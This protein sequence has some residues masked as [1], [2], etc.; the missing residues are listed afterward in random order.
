[1]W[2]LARAHLDSRPTGLGQ[3]NGNRL[4]SGPDV[5]AGSFLQSV[6]FL[7]DEFSSLNA[8]LLARARIGA[9]SVDGC[10]FRHGLKVY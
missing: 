10:F 1:L 8:G 6:H 2:A 5:I 9:R 4:L 7:A 3:A